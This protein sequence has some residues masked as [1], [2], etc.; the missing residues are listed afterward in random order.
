MS[1]VVQFLEAL[2]RNP[3]SMSYDEFIAAVAGADLDT[4]VRK[5]LLER[6][7]AALSKQLSV[8]NA[9]FC[10]VFPADNEQPKEGEEQDDGG[11]VPEQ[12]QEPSSKAA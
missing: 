7:V 4:A 2:A 1:N 6:D 3:K 5:A 9:M 12:E 11:E 10:V 8:R